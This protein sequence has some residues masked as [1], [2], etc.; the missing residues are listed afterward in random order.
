MVLNEKKRRMLVEAA[1]K[2]K[3]GAGP[4]DANA[5]APADGPIAVISAP[6][7]Y[8]T[9]PTDLRQKGVVEATASEDEDTCSGLVFKKK[10]A[11]MS[12]SQRS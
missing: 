11:L 9:A 8:A 12:Q 2:L 7:P 1:S 5:A 6:N 4:S 3:A 10:G